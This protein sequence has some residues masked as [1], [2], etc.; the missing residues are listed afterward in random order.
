MTPAGPAHPTRSRAARP[1]RRYRLVVTAVAVGV[2]A[3]ESWVLVG[4]PTIGSAGGAALGATPAATVSP[5]PTPSPTPSPRDPGAVER[6]RLQAGSRWVADDPGAVAVV[7]AGGLLD[8][9]PL[10]VVAAEDAWA[11]GVGVAWRLHAPLLPAGAPGLAGLLDHLG[12]RTVVAVARA[13]PAAATPTPSPPP[14]VVV[15]GRGREVVDVTVGDAWVDWTRLDDVVVPAAVAGPD[16]PVVLVRADDPARPILDTITRAANVS[17][18][19][20]DGAV[21]QDARAVERLRATPGAPWAVAGT[22]AAWAD[23]D[24]QVLDWDVRVVRSGVELPGGGLRMFPGRRLVA[25]YG[26]PE[27]AALGV[28]GEQ[29]VEAAVDRAR[30]LAAEYAPLVDEPVVPTFEIITTVASGGAGANGDYSRRV[31]LDQVEPWVETAAAAGMYVVLDLQPGRTDFLTQAREVEDL[32]RRPHVGLALDPEWRLGPDHV[33]L[34]R[35][36]SVAVEEVQAVA[37]WLA[38]LTREA[39]LPQKLLLLHQFRSSM[40]P[41][42]Q[43][44]RVPPELAVAI[45]MDGQGSQGAKDATWQAVTTIDPPA[46]VWFGWKNFHDEDVTLRSPADTLAV[47]PSPVFVSHQ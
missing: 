21:V 11:P 45:Q 8:A 9:A 46:G 36:G 20:V 39:A 31:P 3:A 25:L 40:L 38:T 26:S 32:L 6:S 34:R 41:D 1:T 17:L 24:P 29:P 33:H 10:V 42:R 7:A 12:T 47:E 35:V 44:L 37:D 18:L 23:V 14:A 4:E 43:R 30:A 27:T 13:A 15:P 2:L 28:L 16:A 19:A 22:T 5:S